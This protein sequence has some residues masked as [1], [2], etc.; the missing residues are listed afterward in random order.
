MAEVTGRIGDNDVALENAATEATLRALLLAMSGSTKK[1]DQLINLAS[2]S[3]MN[4][5]AIEQANKGANA[6]GQA[7]FGAGKIA[8]AAMSGLSKSALVLGGIIGDLTASAFKTV[9]N[10]TDFAG[11]LLDG[12]ASV[13]GLFGALKDLPL[14]LNLVAGLFEKLAQFQE[15]NLNAF[16]DLS[17]VGVNLGGDL[18]QV[19]LQA[20]EAGLTMEQYG[21]VIKENA[22]AIS[23][24]GN[25]TDDGARAFRGITKALTTGNLGNNLLSLGYG[26][27]EINDLAANYIKVNSGLTDAQKKDYRGVSE[28]IANYGKELDVMARLT[29][30]SREQLEKQQEEMTMDSNFQAY[31]NTLDADE[32]DKANAAMRLAMES[33]GKGAVDALKSRLMN[34]PPLTEEAKLYEAT[35]QAGRQSIEDFYN[36]IKNGKPLQESQLLL[37]KA[38]SKAVSGNIKDLKQFETVMRAGGMTGDKFATTLMGVQEKVLTYQRKG[39]TEEQAIQQAIRDERAKQL[40]QN[41]SAAAAAAKAEQALKALGSELMGAMLPVFEAVGPIVSQ[42]ANSLLNFARENMPAIQKGA[43]MLGDFLQRF[44]KDIFTEEGREK[45]VNDILWAFKNILIEVKK[46]ILPSWLYDETDAENDRKKLASEKAVYD[47]RAEAARVA[48]DI[49]TRESRLQ[50]SDQAAADSKD[51]LTAEE[52][53]RAFG[54]VEWSKRN[55]NARIETMCQRYQ[56]GLPLSTS[57]VKEVKRF[58]RGK[59]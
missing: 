34:L 36:I 14:G 30:K 19:R 42:L 2:K 6:L 48:N 28:S 9:G 43:Q 18:N 25:S 15:S 35:M 16:R 40:K 50:K 53:A 29:G 8:S 11:K 41:N 55:P 13:S 4:P 52:K 33:G 59:L 24:L 17:K 39:M 23:G 49:R 3:G 22:Q 37:D 21:A 32:R 1:M 12:T 56:D 26:F 51:K 46:G 27:R 58:L 45:I 31:L 5:K 47:A 7:A 54:D 20:L 44:V 38:F 57:D 10:L